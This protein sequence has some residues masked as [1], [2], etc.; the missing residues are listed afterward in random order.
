MSAVWNVFQKT[1]DEYGN[2]LAT[3]TVCSRS[4]KVPKSRTTTN[5]LAHL[6]NNHCDKR[7]GSTRRRFDA[8]IPSSSGA[9]GT[10]SHGS[11]A[12][13]RLTRLV[14][15]GALLLEATS[16][17]SFRDFVNS[18]NPSYQ[19]PSIST[20]R[21]ILQ[22]DYSCIETIN[23]RFLAES[24]S[25]IAL[26][27]D[28]HPTFRAHCGLLVVNVD[29]TQI[30]TVVANEDEPMQEAA[31]YL[32]TKFVPCAA[33]SI[34]LAVSDTI[35]AKNSFKVLEKVRK[36]VSEMNHNNIAK[37]QLK[38]RLKEFNLPEFCPVPDSPTRWNSTYDLICEV[39][40][41]WPA[42]N[43]VLE[44]LNQ[45][46]LEIDDMRFLET[47]R[48]FLEPFSTLTKQSF[49][50]AQR[51]GLC[52]LENTSKYFNPWLNDEF[53]Q[54]AACLDP[55]FAYLETI[56]SMK[57]WMETVE[58]F[59]TN[60]V[61]IS[62]SKNRDVFQVGQ[63]AFLQELRHQQTSVWEIL[64]ESRAESGVK[65]SNSWNH[66]DELR[67]ELQHYCG[68]LGSSR[69]A[70]GTDP[71]HWWRAFSNE[72]PLLSKAALGYLATPATSVDSERFMS[73]NSVPTKGRNFGSTI[74]KFDR[75]LMT[76]KANANKD[77]SRE[78][79]AWSSA[80]IYKYS[81]E[82]SSKSDFHEYDVEEDAIR[83]SCRSDE[84]KDIT[85]SIKPLLSFSKDF[86]GN[87][88]SNQLE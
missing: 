7:I 51:F 73:L 85:E 29:V 20:L 55:R 33:H 36:L 65:S 28:F 68:I 47:I 27:L 9:S 39:L 23:R 13:R 43:D 14:M 67:A 15:D 8:T 44:K 70:F 35:C 41:T 69:P 6:R 64:R 11:R 52:L 30:A 59:V 54:T 1:T 58:K 17:K 77:V 88:E 16:L 61:N 22:E 37:M 32:H 66:S 72:F 2:V 3:C 78:C 42:L 40:I 71:L 63:E 87:M 5:L 83:S 45:P 25:K 79:K 76:L 19:I 62:S 26:T 46:L 56:Q 50:E 48:A 49:G 82:E 31:L 12:H 86:L 74:R 53:L 4:L 24:S 57:S 60:Q 10:E 34:H 38:S 84:E 75:L 81:F 21:N 18:L 80:D